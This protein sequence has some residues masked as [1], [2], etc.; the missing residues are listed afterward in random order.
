MTQNNNKPK[1][2]AQHP[3]PAIKLEKQEPIEALAIKE[4]PLD[5]TDDQCNDEDEVAILEDLATL[6]TESETEYEEEQDE[7]H[8]QSTPNSVLLLNPVFYLRERLN[9]AAGR[10]TIESDTM[11]RPEPWER[12]VK[13]VGFYTLTIGF[14]SYFVNGVKL[15]AHIQSKII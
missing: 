7:F 1:I 9:T 13:T 6:S 4:E 3:F 12:Y 14:V 5:S 15:Y 8:C 2:P 11:G 10:D